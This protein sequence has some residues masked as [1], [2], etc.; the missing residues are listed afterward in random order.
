MWSGERRRTHVQREPVLCTSYMNGFLNTST[1][2]ALGALLVAGTLAVASRTASAQT[3]APSRAASKGCTWERASDKAAGFAAWVL[4][5]DYG[6][7]KIHFFLKGNALMQQY[8]DAGATPDAVIESFELQPNE[9]VDAGVRRVYLAHTTKAIADRCVIAPYKAGKAPADVKRLTFV[10][11]AKYAK[12]VKAKA[13]PEEVGDPPCGDWG[14]TPDGQQFFQVW[15]TS[16]ARRLL[17]VRIGQDTP[18]FDEMTLQL[19][20]TPTSVK[21]K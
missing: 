15:P 9:T 4:R 7:R 5:C 12:A 13:D 11:N 20:S 2:G 14:T 19:L 17:F 21:P 1:R 16:A 8:S 6:T 3:G 18:L 10:P